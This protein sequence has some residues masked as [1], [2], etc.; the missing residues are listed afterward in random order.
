MPTWNESEWSIS[1]TIGQDIRNCL[2]TWYE[3]IISLSA[4]V[5]VLIIILAV[6]SILATAKERLENY[7]DTLISEA[8]RLAI[9]LGDKTK[10]DE[11]G[12]GKGKRS[13]LR[14]EYHLYLDR[15][16]ENLKIEKPAIPSK[17]YSFFRPWLIKRYRRLQVWY[18]KNLEIYAKGVSSNIFKEIKIFHDY[19]QG[20]LDPQAINYWILEY[21]I[22]QRREKSIIC[23]DEIKK[24]IENKVREVREDISNIPEDLDID[25]SLKNA[26]S[27]LKEMDF[28]KKRICRSWWKLV[29]IDYH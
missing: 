15:M 28:L 11:I 5:G 7:L 27:S 19:E 13:K 20:E 8:G 25:K 22:N 4:I 14:K 17:I 9:K 29:E 3:T 16:E 18:W 21:L 26:L 24:Q 2:S 12:D 23:E 10:V 1:F 6:L